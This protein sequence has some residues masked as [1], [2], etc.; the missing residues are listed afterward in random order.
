VQGRT[1]TWEMLGAKAKTFAETLHQRVTDVDCWGRAK[2]LADVA[3]SCGHAMR[4]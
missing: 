4:V 2:Q 1:L 3:A